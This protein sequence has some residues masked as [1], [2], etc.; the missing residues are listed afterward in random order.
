ME[1]STVDKEAGYEIM[2][3]A[4]GGVPMRFRWNFEIDG[5]WSMSVKKSDGSWGKPEPLIKNISQCHEL[6]KHFDLHDFR[7]KLNFGEIAFLSP[8]QLQHV[9]DEF[10]TIH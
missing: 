10:V 1:E 6:L 4:T 9:R 5:A 3:H 7:D 8:E 2:T